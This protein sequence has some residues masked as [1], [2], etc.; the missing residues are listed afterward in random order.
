MMAKILTTLALAVLV[1]TLGRT[2]VVIWNSETQLME[3]LKLVVSWKVFAGALV[4]GGARTFHG[5]ISALLGRIAVNQP[6][7]VREAA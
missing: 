4:A 7:Q 6:K 3:L 2:L 1:V 5:E